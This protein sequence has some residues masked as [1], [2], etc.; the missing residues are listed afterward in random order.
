MAVT[1]IAQT[2]LDIGGDD[3]LGG[4]QLSRQVY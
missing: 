3:G 4:Y 1:K 2:W